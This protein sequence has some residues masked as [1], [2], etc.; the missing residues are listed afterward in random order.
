M[1]GGD[2]ETAEMAVVDEREREREQ[3]EAALPMMSS[4]IGTVVTRE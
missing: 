2:E 1:S 3:T 4:H